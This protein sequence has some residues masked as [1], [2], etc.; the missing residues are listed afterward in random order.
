M[1]S[2]HAFEK[3]INLISSEYIPQGHRFNIFEDIGCYPATYDTP[4]AY[5]LVWCPP[6]AIGLVSAVYAVLSIKAFNKS[7]TQ[8]NELLSSYSNLTSSRYVRLMC[9]AGIELLC[10][11]PLGTYG[12]Y[13][14]IKTGVSPWISW[15]NVHFDF[16]RVILVPALLWR[17]GGVGETSLELSRWLIIVCAFIFFG[18][19]GFAD[20]A[21][22]NYR[23]ALETVAKRVGISTSLGSSSTLTSSTGAKSKIVSSSGK[24]RPVAP[25]FVHTEFFRRQGSISSLTDISIGDVSGHLDEKHADEKSFSPTLSYGAITLADVGGTLADY[26]ETPISPLPSSGSS[27]SASSIMSSPASTS[28]PSLPDPTAAKSNTHDIV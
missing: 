10:T 21:K 11:V 15:E 1:R 28:S 23:S 6:V 17:D 22:K 27:S 16:S 8:F 19:F 13:L 7:R 9:L 12:I 2:Q 4:V 3:A 14:N 18:F 26:V 5:V 24:V 25:T 20:E